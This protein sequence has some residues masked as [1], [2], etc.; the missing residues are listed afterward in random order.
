MHGKATCGILIITISNET[1]D[2][3]ILRALCAIV[4]TDCP[5]GSTKAERKGHNEKNDEND[6]KTSDQHA[7][8]VG[9]GHDDAA[10]GDVGGRGGGARRDDK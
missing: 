9:D 6:R 3:M 2:D 10:G 4:G 7:P 5:H 8:G 1:K